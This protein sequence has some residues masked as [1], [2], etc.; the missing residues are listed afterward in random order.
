MCFTSFVSSTINRLNGNVQT[1]HVID[2]LSF[3]F[4]VQDSEVSIHK[5]TVKKKGIYHLYTFSTFICI[6]IDNAVVF[7]S[8]KP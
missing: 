5:R 3:S 7:Q 8:F 6:T 4:N 1:N 2:N